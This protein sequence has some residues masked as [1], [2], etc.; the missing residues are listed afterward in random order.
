MTVLLVTH[1]SFE[2]HDTGAHHPERPGRLM[3]L[4]D[5]LVAHGL[6]EAVVELPAP[7]APLESIERVHTQD[8]VERA[9]DVCAS[10]GHLD[11]DT[12][13]VPASWEASRRAAG[14]GLAAIQALDEGR[15]TTAFCA[16]RP[17]G[18]HATPV[19]SMGFCVF[20]NVAVAARALT[21]R[22]ERVFIADIDA[23]H[24]N[25]TQDVFYDDPEVL[26]ASWHQWP[27]Y[28]GSGAM[29]ETGTGA[30]QGTTINVPLPPGATGDHYRSSIERVIA[31]VVARFAPT[32]LLISAGFDAHRDD[33]LTTM[34]LTSGDFADIVSDLLDATGLPTIAF[35]EGG[36][37]LEAVAASAAATIGVL[38]GER[39]HPERPTSGGPGAVVVD[40]VQE[41]HR[42]R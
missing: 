12:V 5:G 41:I 40:Q 2:G 3:A 8:M 14:A 31:P 37:D 13:C 26:F 42:E 4:R 39:P 25:G 24:G 34:G 15:H 11:P 28:P 38:A 10:G 6:D 20:N 17:P 35:L 33:P 32:W 16:V 21:A 19:R 18:H 7:L 36:Y 23:H 22:G 9:R 27:L 29:S 1:E 30:G